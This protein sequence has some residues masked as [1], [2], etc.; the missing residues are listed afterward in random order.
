MA[1]YNRANH[2]E[3]ADSKLLSCLDDQVLVVPKVRAALDVGPS[4]TCRVVTPCPTWLGILALVS[5]SVMQ[6]L[7]SSAPSRS[8]RA[9][10]CAQ[11][12]AA[13]AAISVEIGSS[14]PFVIHA[15]RPTARRHYIESWAFEESDIVTPALF[16][17]LPDDILNHF[18]A[19]AL[20]LRPSA[21]VAQHSSF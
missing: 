8:S 20:R 4:R 13:A 16:E 7:R 2:D 12:L 11:K 10:A 6:K 15:S 21:V 5:N 1:L 19:K 3:S 18:I 14:R 17:D 9:V